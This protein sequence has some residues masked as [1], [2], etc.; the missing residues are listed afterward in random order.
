MRHTDGAGIAVLKQTGFHRNSEMKTLLL[1]RHAKASHDENDVPD[2]ERRLTR[3]G[4]EDAQLVGRRLRKENLLPDLIISSHAVRA[5]K[6]AKR[7]AKKS[8]Y[9]G[10]I[11]LREDLY[12]AG[13]AAHFETI[14][15]IDDRLSR[16]MIVGHNP[17]LS[18]FLDQLTGKVEPLETAALAIVELPIDRWRALDKTT[19][20]KLIGEWLPTD[21]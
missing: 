6:T 11:E 12:L 8:H 21:S 14:Q 7:V 19:H 10:P 3:R 9:D 20:A 16:V 17:G 18:E 4:K 5:R 2:L 1:L 13:P 15:S